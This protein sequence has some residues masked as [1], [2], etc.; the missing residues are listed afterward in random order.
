MSSL[1]IFYVQKIYYQGINKGKE[2]LN[3][4][5]FFLLC[6]QHFYPFL[7]SGS[8]SS[9]IVLIFFSLMFSFRISK[10][11]QPTVLNFCIIRGVQSLCVETAFELLIE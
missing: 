10:G 7:L 11:V 2:T 3:I 8:A 4:K 9:R 5:V 1:G 6:S